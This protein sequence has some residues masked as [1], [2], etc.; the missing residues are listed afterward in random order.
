MKDFVEHRLALEQAWA[1]TEPMDEEWVWSFADTQP[2]VYSDE[3]K[4]PTS[5][6]FNDLWS[7]IVWFCTLVYT[8]LILYLIFTK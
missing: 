1:E 8:W 6:A 4:L 7:D 3:R 5:S 2:M